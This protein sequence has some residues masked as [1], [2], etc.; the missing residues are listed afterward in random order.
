VTEFSLEADTT[1]R[2]VGDQVLLLHPSDPL[3]GFRNPYLFPL[4]QG[5]LDIEEPLTARATGVLPLFNDRAAPEHL[6]Y[7]IGAHKRVLDIDAPVADPEIERV[8]RGVPAATRGSLSAGGGAELE[9]QEQ[10]TETPAWGACLECHT[11]RYGPAGDPVSRWLQRSALSAGAR[12]D[13]SGAAG[14]LADV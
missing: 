6:R 14:K 11:N 7:T 4:A 10:R 8:V 12:V 9:E 1:P 5:R 2:K 3:G 13:T